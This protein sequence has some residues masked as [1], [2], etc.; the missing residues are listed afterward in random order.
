MSGYTSDAF[1]G[2]QGTP[3]APAIKNAWGP[4]LN[5][6]TGIIAQLAT[7][8][9][10]V[11]I[12]GLGTYTLTTANASSDQARPLM[13]DFTGAL[14]ANCTVTI[15]NVNR[16]AMVRNSTTGGRNVLLTSG[17]GTQATI[18]PDGWWHPYWCDGSGNVSLPNM[19][20]DNLKFTSISV[21]GTLTASGIITAQS[22]LSVPAGGA[23]I[24]GDSQV[25]GA[26]SVSTAGSTSNHVVNFSQFASSVT[27]P[28]Y[29]KLPNG[30]IFQLGTNTTGAGLLTVTFPL[31]FPTACF[32]VYTSGNQN[33][34]S[35]VN[36]FNFTTTTFQAAGVAGGSGGA[37]VPFS[38][39][40]IGH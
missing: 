35:F 22:G 9:T 6:N 12:A 11:N 26:L 5:A 27:N 23:S 30:W 7:G 16:W 8:Y 34:N 19:K 28:G 25:V 4:F 21:T 10:A 2:W 17:G 15:P 40:A 32:C 3:G 24:V 13:I 29:T 39:L 31:A 33:A 36:A 38:W 14:A 20:I 1:R 37:T 18:S